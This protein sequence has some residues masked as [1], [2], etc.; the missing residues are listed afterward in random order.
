MSSS[1]SSTVF[2]SLSAVWL[3]LILSKK[4][5]M[6]TGEVIWKIVT[7]QAAKETLQR[8][9]QQALEVKAGVDRSVAKMQQQLKDIQDTVGSKL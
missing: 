9:Q 3:L 8:T 1:F 5:A 7:L 6:D 4:A 2:I